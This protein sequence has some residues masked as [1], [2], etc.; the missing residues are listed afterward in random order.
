VV[1]I[2]SFSFLHLFFFFRGGSMSSTIAPKSVVRYRPYRSSTV[3]TEELYDAGNRSRRPVT[4][5]HPTKRS[6]HYLFFMVL[7][8]AGMLLCVWLGQSL[9]AWISVGLDDFHYGRPRTFHIDATVGHE[10]GTTPSHF[11]AMNLQGRI[12]IVELPGG[13]ASKPHVYVG[14]QLLGPD[15]ALVPITLRF[16]DTNNDGQPDMIVQFR[17]SQL[18]YLNVKGTFQPPDNH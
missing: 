1:G 17:N 9:F 12:H 2:S 16:N 18:I 11:I 10:A 14:P 7:G 4:A 13:D 5:A 15:A 3:V 8:M 6:G